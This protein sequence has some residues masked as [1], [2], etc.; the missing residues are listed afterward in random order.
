M[1]AAS[2]DSMVIL[3]G[4]FDAGYDAAELLELADPV[5]ANQV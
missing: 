4:L 1:M 2:D 3:G 5:G